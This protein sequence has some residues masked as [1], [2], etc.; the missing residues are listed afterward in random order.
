MTE[1]EKVIRGLEKLKANEGC[2][3][4]HD[5]DCDTCPYD[6]KDGCCGAVVSDAI[7]LL[8]AQEPVRPH[9]RYFVWV[10]GKCGIGVVAAKE[11]ERPGGM[12]VFG[13]KKS[14]CSK[15]GCEVRWDD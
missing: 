14:F 6:G 11:E 9:E 12:I 2:I 13:S 15:C 5:N 10:C 8:K 3:S 1:R 4:V 7:A